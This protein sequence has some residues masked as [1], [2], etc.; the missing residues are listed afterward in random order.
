MTVLVVTGSRRRLD[1]HPR[2]NAVLWLLLNA[3]R[4]VKLSGF[5]TGPSQQSAVENYS[6]VLSGRLWWVGG[7]RGPGLTRLG[8]VSTRGGSDATLIPGFPALPHDGTMDTGDKQSGR[9]GGEDGMPLKLF[10]ANLEV[11]VWLAKP[12]V[13]EMHQL[14]AASK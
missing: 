13:S 14:A 7:Y 10:V 11:W 9:R 12:G 2:S 1:S 5:D 8:F 6:V 4:S 3:G